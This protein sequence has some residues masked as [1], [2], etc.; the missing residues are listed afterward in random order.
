MCGLAG[1]VT[2]R[3]GDPDDLSRTG[4]AMAEAL[5]HRGPDKGAVWTDDAAGAVLAHRRL[6]TIDLTPA[7]EQPMVSACG[8][9][10]IVYNGEIYNAA[11]VARD[12]PGISWRGHS[13]TE[14]LLEACAAWGVRAALPR[15]IGMFAFALWDRRDRRLTL[16]RDR[17]GIK[18]L[19]YGR[20]NGLFLYGSELKALRAHPGFRSAIDPA[21]VDRFLQFAYIPDAL[22]IY[23]GIAKLQPG[24]LLEVTADGETLS[25]WWDLLSH[26]VAGQAAPDRRPEAELTEDLDRLLRDA[27]ARRMVADVPLGA[28]LSGGID[29]S[30]V[31]ALMQAQSDRPVKTFS[32]GFREGAFNEADHARAV[33]RHLRT[34]HTELIV[35]PSQARDVIPRLADMFDEPFADSSQI[36]TFLVS[37]L[38]RRHVTVSLSGDGGDEVFAGYTRYLGIE[39]LWRKLG[40][41]PALPR[42]CAAALL[43]APPPAVWDALFSP[44][45]ARFK[46]SHFGDKIHKGADLIG[47]DDPDGMYRRVVSQWPGD[48]LPSASPAATYRAA[49]D[50]TDLADRLPDIVSR[51]RYRD[52]M[53]YLPEDILTKVD[54]ASMAVSLEARVPLL[55]HR[56]VEFSWTLPRDHLIRKRTGKYLLCRVL[57]RYVPRD[58][59]DRP[60][61]GFSVPIGIWL[62]GPLREWGEDLLSAASLRQTG[63]LDPA[64]IRAAWTE[65]QS[66]T[67]NWQHRLWCALMLQAWARRWR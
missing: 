54:R 10:V 46:P 47:F 20:Q 48:R 23:R 65:H 43:H 12:L 17:L 25:C 16:V 66:G 55:D 15:F 40:H 50:R 67:R 59:I 31:V 35:S 9:W 28:F 56:V 19:Y 7:G 14:A 5:A 1:F 11:E 44:V 3:P 2:Y 21:A 42:R 51:L 33:A 24:H 63:L 64:P 52:L 34:D 26:A 49:W 57:D 45:P 58:L 18:P 6:A 61:M 27:V 13:D 4:L 36:P 39:T 62:R 32:I 22:S 38:A 60:K 8:R 41:V 29:S 37:E 53:S 30:T